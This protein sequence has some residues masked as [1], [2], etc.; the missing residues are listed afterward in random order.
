MCSGPRAAGVLTQ[1]AQLPAEQTGFAS[2]GHPQ[3]DPALL[4]A[5]SCLGGAVLDG[6]A[7][8][9]QAPDVLDV[10]TTL[11]LGGW[12]VMRLWGSPPWGER[13]REA[14]TLG[15]PRAGRGLP[16]PPLVRQ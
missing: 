6:V 7:A 16:S 10:R 13:R 8:D 1:R 3:G 5:S 15:P 12:Q 4:R 9:N 14:G 2:P 11:G